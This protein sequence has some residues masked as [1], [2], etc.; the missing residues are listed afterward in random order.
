VRVLV[1]GGRG[2]LASVLLPCLEGKHEVTGVDIQ[3][4]DITAE[5]P[6]RQAFQDLRPEFVFH[7]AAYTDVDGCEANPARAD[8]VNVHGTRNLARACAETG[9]TLLYVST[10]Y[11]FDGRLS[12][13]YREDDA[14][15]PESVYGYSKWRGEQVVQA[16]VAKHFIVRTSWLFGP[17]GK[18]FVA[19][20]LKAAKERGELRVVSDQRGSPTYTGHL[21]LHLAQF[22][23]SEAFGIF[24]VTGSGECSWFEFAQ[25]IVK[26]GGLPHVRVTPI[27][28]EELGRPAK[29]PA[30]SVLENRRLGQCHMGPLPHWMDGLAAYL[31]EGER[32]GEF[33][34]PHAEKPA[35]S[36]A[37][38]ANRS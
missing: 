36:R 13:P 29:R 30:N 19:T 1:T 24:H 35:R 4:F 15:H 7:L 6:V 23:Q 37:V 26:T 20:I 33:T 34:L 5:T 28:S 14:P 38:E 16:L 11:V 25:E 3:D 31:K 2:M 32:L 9:A 12:R 10:D 22:P 17:R 18:N 21:A 27:T 8:E